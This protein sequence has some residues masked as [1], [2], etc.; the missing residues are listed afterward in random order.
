MKQE[1][2]DMVRKNR[3]KKKILITYGN[4]LSDKIDKSWIYINMFIGDLY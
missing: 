3:L 1:S 2:N 4:D